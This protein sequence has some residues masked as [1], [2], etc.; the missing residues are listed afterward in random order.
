[1]KRIIGCLGVA[2]VM[3][4]AVAASSEAALPELGR[5][6]KTEGGGYKNAS[7]TAPAATKG[8]YAWLPG[9]GAKS[10]FAGVG[11]EVELE[12]ASKRKITCGGSTFEG[13]YTG[14]KTETVTVLLVG[15]LDS[16][17]KKACQTVQA[18]EGEIESAPLE[19]E[20]GFIK[21]GAKPSVGLDLKHEGV[22]VTFECGKP[23]AQTASAVVE[24]SFIG[25]IAGGPL[26]NLNRMFEESVMKYKAMSGKQIPEAFEG[27]PK[28]TLT[29]TIFTGLQKTVEGIA[30]RGSVSDASEEPLEIKAK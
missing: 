11:N 1:M 27:G 7:C 21:G 30:V 23:P 5:C 22:V 18:R 13:E 29:A 24:G 2:M 10:K 19:G 28:D 6:V 3:L 12:T 26:S 4:L 14:P 16:A 25:A 20:Y 8:K 15:C 17:T 9:P